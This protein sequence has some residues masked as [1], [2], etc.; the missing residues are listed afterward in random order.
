MPGHLFVSLL[1]ITSCKKPT[2]ADRGTTI[3]VQ[4][5]GNTWIALSGQATNM[6]R[7]PVENAVVG[8]GLQ[9]ATTDDQGRYAISTALVTGTAV[10]S[11]EK[12]GFFK[13]YPP[14]TPA[15]EENTALP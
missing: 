10:I 13:G 4:G 6:P 2:E 15:K 8:A 12:S 3:E 14:S 1:F 7:L 5:A 9:T 11:I